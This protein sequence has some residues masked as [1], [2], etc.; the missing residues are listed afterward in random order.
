MADSDPSPE[1]WNIVTDNRDNFSID[2]I[3]ISLFLQKFHL[4]IIGAGQISKS[5]QQN[6][7]IF[8]KISARDNRGIP[9]YQVAS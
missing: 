2:V 5:L 3:K 9:K 8:A 7:F 6:R 1:N 4:V